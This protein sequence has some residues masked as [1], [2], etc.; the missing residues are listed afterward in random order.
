MALRTL[1]LWMHALCGIAWVGICASFV[2]ATSAL[3]GESAEREDVATRA[4]PRINR[5]CIALACLIPLSGLANLTFAAE[6]RRF[7][8]PAEFIAIVCAKVALFSAMA[9]ALWFAWAIAARQPNSAGAEERIEARGEA[10]TKLTKLYGLTV[11]MGAAA[12]VLG[13]W[14]SGT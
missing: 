5:V 2:I 6:A 14:L 10:T 7:V 9:L 3:G 4:A 11:A 12:L 8:L 1:V 13:L